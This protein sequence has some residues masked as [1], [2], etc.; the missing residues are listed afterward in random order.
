MT[1]ASCALAVKSFPQCYGLDLPTCRQTTVAATSLDPKGWG[2][3]EERANEAAAKLSY[4]WVQHLDPHDFM[5]VRACTPARCAAPGGP[6]SLPS[7]GGAAWVL[8]LRLCAPVPQRGQRWRSLART[9]GSSQFR[10]C[11]GNGPC[12]GARWRIEPE[13]HPTWTP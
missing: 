2:Q 11:C 8:N 4:A 13:F 7:A 9:P 6:A 10:G 12:G 3:H 5:R 1:Q